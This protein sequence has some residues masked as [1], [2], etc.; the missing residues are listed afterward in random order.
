MKETTS[1]KKSKA[2]PQPDKCTSTILIRLNPKDKLL[3]EQKASEAGVSMS[4][5]LRSSSLYPVR[6]RN[7]QKI[8]ADINKLAIEVRRI[9]VNLNQLAKWANT[10]KSSAD[11]LIVLSRLMEIES[12]IKKLQGQVLSIDDDGGADAD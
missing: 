8:K 1:S 6:R 10:Y 2:K 5:F 11:N 4:E 3:L 9:G 12:A 7:R